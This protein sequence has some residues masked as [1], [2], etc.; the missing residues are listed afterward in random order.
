MEQLK[1]KHLMGNIVKFWMGI[2]HVNINSR[3]FYS[4]V[5]THW[6]FALY[7][8]QVVITQISCV[9]L[10]HTWIFHNFKIFKIIRQFLKSRDSAHP[11]YEYLW[12]EPSPLYV[13]DGVFFVLT[14]LNLWGVVQLTAQGSKHQTFLQIV[15]HYTT[16]IVLHKIK[17][18]L[19]QHVRWKSHKFGSSMHCLFVLPIPSAWDYTVNSICCD[20][21]SPVV[22][23]WV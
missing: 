10:H 15:L 21:A 20:Q 22:S 2:G 7:R 6:L 18:E 12:A 8:I 16:S 14:F 9:G 11:V 5:S 1:Q 13:S 23:S 3:M 19:Q 4:W 17:G